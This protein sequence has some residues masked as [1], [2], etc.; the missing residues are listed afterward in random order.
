MPLGTRVWGFGKVLLLAGALAMTF[1]V[2]AALAMRV[3]VRARQVT[4]PNLV[5]VS[6][7]DATALAAPLDLSL[8]IDPLKRPDPKVPAGHVLLQ[9]PAAGAAAR[10]QRSVRVVLSDGARIARA[11]SLLGETQ[12]SAE[13]RVAQDGLSIGAVTEI[14]SALYPPDVVVAQDPPPATETAEVRLLVNRG[15]DRAAYVMPDLIGLNGDRAA[16]VMRMRGFRV[17]ITAQSAASSIPPGVV[18]RQAPA[19]GYQ[20]H[21]GD[22]IAL[23][24]SR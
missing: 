18:V 20:V 6:L 22:P 19:G 13:I 23:E 14:R 2:F 10:R 12:R 7:A 4:V 1:L 24:V 5:G 11:P 21:P 17:S 15:E 16:D 3:A 8:R 9:D